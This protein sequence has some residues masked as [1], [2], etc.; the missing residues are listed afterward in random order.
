MRLVGVVIVLVVLAGCANE[1]SRWVKP[2]TSMATTSTEY[3]RCEREAHDSS[4]RIDEINADILATRGNDWQRTGTLSSQQADMAASSRGQGQ[5]ALAACM[6]A[7]G[8]S[9][10]R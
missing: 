3:D 2:G 7:K 5:R 8:F 6:S 1:A 4:R 10:A 9:P